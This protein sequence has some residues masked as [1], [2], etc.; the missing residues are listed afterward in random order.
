M[1]AGRPASS[2]VRI[3]TLRAASLSYNAVFRKVHPPLLCEVATAHR[4]AV[5]RDAASTDEKTNARIVR[6][7]SPMTVL[8][9]ALDVWAHEGFGGV[10]ARIRAR[11]LPR[12]TRL[13]LYV[14]VL[15]GESTSGRLDPRIAEQLQRADRLFG[16]LQFRRITPADDQELDELTA[17]DPWQISKAVSLEKLAE[18][19]LCYV[20]LRDGKVVGSTWSKVGGSFADGV[21]NRTY[22]LE[23]DEAYHWRGFCVPE[24]RAR[25]VVPRLMAHVMDDLATREGVRTHVGFVRPDNEAQLRTLEQLGFSVAGRVGFVEAMGARLNY[26]WGAR[27][28]RA[29]R[30]RLA[31][32]LVRR[33][34]R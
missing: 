1:R 22:V 5:V 14:M 8:R 31:L 34:S 6:L 29:T 23:P 15:G 3:I 12:W 24:Q 4:S 19:W 25:A 33:H 13:H 26:L 7:S 28:L 32:T 10:W 18:G 2:A 17:V 9:R 21:L 20:A 27:A 11:A 30:K 16:A